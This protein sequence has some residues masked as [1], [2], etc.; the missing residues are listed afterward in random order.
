M[1]EKLP[2]APY[3]R[4]LVA[5]TGAEAP[6]STTNGKGVFTLT[7]GTTYYFPCGGIS[8]PLESIQLRGFT[9][10][11]VITSAMV[12]VTNEVIDE[13][14]YFTNDPGAWH[15]ENPTTAYVPVE[16]TGWAVTVST[17]TVTASGA[18]IG[19]GFWNMGNEGAARTRLAVVV[20]GTG[21]DVRCS[22]HGKS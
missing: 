3:V 10:G 12:E 20:G 22:V 15:A 5:T 6:A 14:P 13:T 11:L 21:G 19:G 17:A 4:P 8:A 9:A 18:G 16:G 2:N 7:A 1:I